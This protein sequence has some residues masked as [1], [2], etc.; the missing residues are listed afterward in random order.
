MLVRLHCLA[1]AISL[2]GP[3]LAS[4]RA[5]CNA[6]INLSHYDPVTPNFTEVRHEGVL[7]VIHEAMFPPGGGDPKYAERQAEATRAGLLWG[8][9]HFANNSDPERQ[10]DQLM[11][12]VTSHP[13]SGEAR[14]AGVLLVLDFEQNTH[15]PGGTMTVRQAAQFVE[16]VHQRT[17]KYP[18]LY[19]N[20][21]RIRGVLNGPAA[22]ASS[23]AVLKHCWLWVANYHHP[24]GPVT[25]WSRWTM[26]QYT[27][28]GVCE[29]PRARYPTHVA[30][31][32][33]VERNIC[34]GSASGLSAFWRENGWVF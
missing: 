30:N 24:P 3:L 19:S 7:G 23:L 1:V 32:R 16:R 2:F 8:A 27:G 29:M 15:Y 14:A 17:G 28:D 34:A 26:W 25:P 6:V 33:E 31:I 18:G 5:D 13:P 12:F 4:A 10:A 9:Y 21:N 20:E 11:S 22:D